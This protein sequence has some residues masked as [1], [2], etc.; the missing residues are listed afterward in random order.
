M[1]RL[2]DAAVKRLPKPAAGN[3]LTFDDAVA[4]FA[5]RV[6]ASGHRGFVLN[7]ETREGRQRRYTI[8]SLGDWTT[9]TPEQRPAGCGR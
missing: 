1:P 8:G 7:Y 4:G 6:T 9:P 5:A 3:R 2:T